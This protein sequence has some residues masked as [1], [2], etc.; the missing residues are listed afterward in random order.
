M[1]IL[2]EVLQEELERLE[3]Q[4]AA[5]L[6]AI[7]ELPRGYISQKNIRGRKSYYL[8]Y[9]EGDKIISQYIS[10]ELLSETEDKIKRRKQ[11]EDSL[12]RVAKDKKRLRKALE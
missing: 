12:H 10:K 6:K 5:Y 8:Q 3:R 1:S 4:E 7:Q 2:T 9:R 11:L